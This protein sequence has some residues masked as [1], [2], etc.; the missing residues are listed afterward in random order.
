[1]KPTLEDLFSIALDRLSIGEDIEK[2]LK[3]YPDYETQLRP[4]LEMSLT[5]QKIQPT[6]EEISQAQNRSRPKLDQAL[7][8]MK[9]EKQKKGFSWGAFGQLAGV[10][11]V[12]I[13]FGGFMAVGLVS[14]L[15]FTGNTG[16][17]VSAPNVGAVMPTSVP[18]SGGNVA[19]VATSVFVMSPVPQV[20]VVTVTPA[21]TQTML[22]FATP[23][24]QPNQNEFEL[25][26][27]SVILEATGTA[28]AMFAPT[29]TPTMVSSS[30]LDLVPLTAGEIDDNANWERYLQYR[31]NFL[32]QQGMAYPNFIDFNVSNRVVVTVV[33][34]EGNPIMGAWVALQTSNES[35]ASQHVPHFTYADGQTQFFFAPASGY[36][37]RA[38]I[39]GIVVTTP[40]QQVA[41]AAFSAERP[42]TD[43][44][45]IVVGG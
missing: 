5:L 25:T 41:T 44:I 24:N 17:P 26:A 36:V 21:P 6:R 16:L 12:M 3:D 19:Y 28:Q 23:V 31:A 18:T 45:T 42:L 38:E 30:D 32:E 27:T 37:D 8:T 29:F 40:E 13:L 10:A 7:N 14:N 4:L 9:P 11:A 2:I 20:N 1:M 39:T 22:A 34:T 15:A 35:F 33:D 43:E